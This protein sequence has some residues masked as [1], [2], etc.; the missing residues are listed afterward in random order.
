MTEYKRDRVGCG[1]VVAGQGRERGEMGSFELSTL[2]FTFFFFYPS[3]S[4]IIINHWRPLISHQN[5][6]QL[7]F[8]F[9]LG[10]SMCNKE[11]RTKRLGASYSLELH[12]LVKHLGGRRRLS[13]FDAG[14]W[15]YMRVFCYFIFIFLRVGQWAWTLHRPRHC[16]LLHSIIFYVGLSTKHQQDTRSTRVKVKARTGCATGFSAADSG[17]RSE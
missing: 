7:P 1:R 8:L 3:L 15:Y 2:P 13:L 10:C 17:E 11:R 6:A 16:F 5:G 9:G 4:C 12:S 14:W